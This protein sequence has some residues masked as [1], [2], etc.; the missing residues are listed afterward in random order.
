MKKVHMIEL[1]VV[2]DLAQNERRGLEKIYDL[3]VNISPV[4]IENL[5]SIILPS[6]KAL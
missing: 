5:Y 1:K 3:S 6:G 2:V 4:W